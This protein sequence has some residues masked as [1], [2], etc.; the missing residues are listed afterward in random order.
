MFVIGKKISFTFVLIMKNV[1]PTPF[2]LP[3][4]QPPIS[5]PKKSIKDRLCK[6]SFLTSLKVI[7]PK[8]GSI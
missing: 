6:I 7:S 3:P 2:P 5:K 8:L 1:G 4:P